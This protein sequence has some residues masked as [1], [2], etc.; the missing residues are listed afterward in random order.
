[1]YTTPFEVTAKVTVK[2]TVNQ[3]KIVQLLKE[4]ATGK[5]C[6]SAFIAKFV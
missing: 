5:S 1:M 4:N 3:Q 2:V 6:D